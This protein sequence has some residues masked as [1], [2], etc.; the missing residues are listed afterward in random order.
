VLHEHEFRV[1]G[2]DARLL[3]RGG[4]DI[5]EPLLH[6]AEQRLL[7][8]ERMLTRFD[9]ESELEQLNAAGEAVVGP[10]LRALLAEAE[11]HR[12]DTSGRFDVGVGARVI[13]AG[14]DRSFELLERAE[15]PVHDEPPSRTVAPRTAP[16]AP[17]YAIDGERVVL[18]PGVR[19]DLGG[20]AK[21]WAADL[22]ARALVDRAGASSLVSLGGDVGVQIVEGDEP[23]PI[24]VDAGTT[25]DVTL[26]L[27]F[28]GMATSGRDRRSWRTADGEH[29][30]HHVIDP[31]TGEPCSTDILRITVVAS[32]CAS[33]EAWATALMQVGSE[34]ATREAE[35]RG[36]ATII[37]R[38]D[39]S[40][41]STGG[42]VL[43]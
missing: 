25:G 11:R 33:A 37:V 15:A 43:D 14:Y 35:A 41:A 22:T 21:G 36:L 18:R 17:P 34:H 12:I 39:G 23:W 29:S 27:A 1:M 40:A 13:A 28:G 6:E 10:V 32:T 7:E 4:G 20:I 9:P 42:L 30:A 24:A 26:A 16:T 31:T 19:L 38:D 5:A 2:S 8:L 3:L